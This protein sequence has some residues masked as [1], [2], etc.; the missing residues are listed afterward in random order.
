MMK[1]FPNYTA[2]KNEIII[3]TDTRSTDSNFRPFTNGIHDRK[4]IHVYGER[5]ERL[6]G[7]FAFVYL[8]GRQS[9]GIAA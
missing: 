1:N 4:V 5:H 7:Y 6:I 8:T 3:H 2:I 9:P